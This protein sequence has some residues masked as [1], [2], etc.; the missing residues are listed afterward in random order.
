MAATD[1]VPDVLRQLLEPGERLLWHARPRPFAAIL[2]AGLTLIARLVLPLAVLLLGWT[3][4]PGPER[5]A[6]GDAIDRAAW[7]TALPLLE[8]RLMALLFGVALAVSLLLGVLSAL[9]RL[10]TA[11][12]RSLDTRYAVTDR[13]LLVLERGRATSI[14]RIAYLRLQRCALGDDLHLGQGIVLRGLLDGDAVKRCLLPFLA[15]RDDAP[16]AAL[17]G[18]RQLA[19]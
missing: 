18:Q 3:L 14:R 10:G 12:A 11:L 4:L 7:A 16:G 2:D 19:L 17:F 1:S 13:R 6:L 15:T 5:A 9:S 8:L